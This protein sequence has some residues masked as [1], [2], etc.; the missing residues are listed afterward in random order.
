MVGRRSG[1]DLSLASINF[2]INVKEMILPG[3]AYWPIGFALNHGDIRADTEAMAMATQIGK[4]VAQLA[5]ILAKNPVPWSYEPRPN[6]EKVRFGD[7]W[8]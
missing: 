3:S 2:F 5:I 7:E 8:K 4:R 6:G 1:I